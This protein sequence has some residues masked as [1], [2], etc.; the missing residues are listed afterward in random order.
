MPGRP[1]T[2]GA[3]GFWISSRL[4]GIALLQLGNA[5]ADPCRS[6]RPFLAEGGMALDQRTLESLRSSSGIQPMQTLSGIQAL[7]QC[8][9][10]NH[11]QM[12]V[13]EGEVAQLHRVLANQTLQA[14]SVSVEPESNEPVARDSSDLLEKT[15]DYLRKQFSTLLKLPASNIDPRADWSG[16]VSIPSWP[17]ASST[18]WSGRSV[19]CPRRCCSNTRTFSH[20][21]STSFGS[22][23]AA[24]NTV[25]ASE[26]SAP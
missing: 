13:M 8:L 6:N 4:L 9:Q 15:R 7:Y 12:L 3:N 17:S 14:Q 25:F 23:A 22:H 26:S 2:A 5:E 1:T 18:T 11:D 21:P 16:T 20:S 19:R 10:S 24:L